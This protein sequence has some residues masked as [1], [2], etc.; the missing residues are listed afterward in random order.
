VSAQ[1]AAASPSFGGLEATKAALQ[2]VLNNR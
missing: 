1:L 2:T